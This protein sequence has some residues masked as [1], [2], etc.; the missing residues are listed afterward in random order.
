MVTVGIL[1]PGTRIVLSYRDRD[2]WAVICP[3]GQVR[4]EATGAVFTNVND[5]ACLIR[6]TRTCD[7]MK[8]WCILEEDG[9]RTSLKKLRDVAREAGTLTARRR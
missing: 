9:I 5:A 2:Y 4:L 3:D 8:F 6:E 1:S 7:G